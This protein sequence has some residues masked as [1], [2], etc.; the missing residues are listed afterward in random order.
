MAIETDTTAVCEPGDLSIEADAKELVEALR[1]VASARS[2][3]EMIR[4]NEHRQVK[5]ALRIPLANDGHLVRSSEL[6]RTLRKVV[7]RAV[8]AATPNDLVLVDFVVVP[9]SRLEVRAGPS[10]EMAGPD[11]ATYEA[12]FGR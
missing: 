4:S 6:G 10:E 8:D 2:T 1:D 3:R 12:I 5:C 9:G 11:R 7:R